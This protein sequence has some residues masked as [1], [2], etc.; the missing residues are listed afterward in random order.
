MLTL[1]GSRNDR[2]W[3]LF[4]ASA[5]K[6]L[7]TLADN[8]IDALVT[9]PPAG[10]GFMNKSWDKNK[11]GRR[12]WIAW[13]TEIMA[14]CYRV[15][16]PG[17][18]G[19]VWAL[20]R[21]SHWTATALDD[22]GFEIRDRINHLFLN[23]FPKSQRADLAIDNALGRKSDRLV[24]GF[25]DPHDYSLSPNTDGIAFG[26]GLA[27][28]TRKQRERKATIYAPATL[29]AAQW[30][31]FGTALKP[32]AEDWILIRKPLDG[33]LADNLIKWGTGAL[34]IDASKIGDGQGA[35]T[36]CTYAPG[37]CQ[38]HENAVYGITY[39]RPKTRAQHEPSANRR[40]PGESGDF[41]MLPG[42]R[43]GSP[44]GRW[45]AHVILDHEVVVEHP[46]FSRYF[47]V[48]KPTTK[49]REAGLDHLPVLTGGQLT[50]R[51]DG[52]DG[53]KNPR[54]GA[55][56]GGGRRNHHPTIKSIELMRY[57]VRL[58]TPPNGVVLDTFAGTCST[59]IG[60]V[61]E[62]FHAV[63]IEQ[64]SSYVDIGACRLA[65]WLG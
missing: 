49:E 62:N 35:G 5:E 48:P 42:P 26:S 58:I 20:P 29:E 13:L 10:I 57:L 24:I 40:Y 34:N 21:T 12:L 37:P 44:D 11:G 38:G 6:A 30:E 7:P 33:T 16:K 43:N 45:P 22:A 39:H 27:S 41:S 50:D 4:E 2:E 23:G 25:K 14:Q 55:G 18:H 61:L 52:S 53:L 46:E 3:V 51:V 31:G 19:L 64:E 9:D 15:M 47:Y 36:T 32:A 28:H 8:S 65:H 56:R 60:A 63:G 54:A 17:A 1:N 59:L